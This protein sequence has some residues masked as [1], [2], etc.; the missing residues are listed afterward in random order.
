MFPLAL[1]HNLFQL[2]KF[3][4]YLTYSILSPTLHI[5]LC[6]LCLYTSNT[7]CWSSLD[8]YHIPLGFVIAQ[9]LFALTHV[10]ICKLYTYNRKCLLLFLIVTNT[11]Y[12]SDRHV[13]QSIEI[14]ARPFTLHSYS[15]GFKMRIECSASPIWV[16]ATHAAGPPTVYPIRNLAIPYEG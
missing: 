4:M 13:T 10:C 12:N 11:T 6:I 14:A 7:L 16:S 15:Q 8:T 2:P 9:I 5:A 3:H 1:F